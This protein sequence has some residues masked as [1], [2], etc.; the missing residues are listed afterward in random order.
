MPR[1]V[2]VPYAKKH[3]GLH[4]D[5][6][7]CGSE[8]GVI[9]AQVLTC[10][11]KQ[12]FIQVTRGHDDGQVVGVIIGT[13]NDANRLFYTGFMQGNGLCPAAVDGT[14]RGAGFYDV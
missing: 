2:A 11:R 1:F 8:D 7:I 9:P 5:I 4:G 12:V 3:A 6:D 10:N 14:F 13:G